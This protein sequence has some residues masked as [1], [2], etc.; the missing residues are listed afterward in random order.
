MTTP[1]LV[2]RLRHGLD[3]LLHRPRDADRE[4]QWTEHEQQLRREHDD[5]AD[6]PVPGL[7]GMQPVDYGT[8]R[9]H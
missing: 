8:R 2:E 5:A 7:R 1:S 6:V 4:R 3:G 9:H